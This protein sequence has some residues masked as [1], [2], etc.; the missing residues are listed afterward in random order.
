M[1]VGVHGV[2]IVRALS[3]DEPMV[4]SA[5]DAWT[6]TGPENFKTYQSRQA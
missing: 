6:S 1:G 3:G 2:A 4:I 5:T